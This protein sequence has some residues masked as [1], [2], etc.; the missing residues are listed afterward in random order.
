MSP[1]ELQV[2]GC[3]EGWPPGSPVSM[4]LG[5]VHASSTLGLLN[6]NGSGRAPKKNQ[7][8]RGDTKRMSSPVGALHDE[9]GVW[10]GGFCFFF[11]KKSASFPNYERSADLLLK[12]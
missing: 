9:N 4:P 2:T 8:F 3:S 12:I 1:C 7:E 10:R 5:Q 11:I 6:S